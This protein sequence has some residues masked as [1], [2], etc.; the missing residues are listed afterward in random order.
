MQFLLSMPA[1]AEWL[2][3]ILVLSTILVFAGFWIYTIVDVIRSKFN[4]DTTKIVWLL[5]VI[6]LG[7]LGSIIYWVIGRPKRV[8]IDN[9]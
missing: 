6:L 1:G 8:T 5:V 7:F 9:N 2:L 4:D 3:V